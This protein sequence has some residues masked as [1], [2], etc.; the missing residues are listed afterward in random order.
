MI[1]QI[2]RNRFGFNRSRRLFDFPSKFHC[3]LHFL[4]SKRFLKMVFSI[5]FRVLQFVTFRIYFCFVLFH[6]Y[7]LKYGWFCKAFFFLLKKKF[8]F[9][10]A[11]NSVW[12]LCL[13][14]K[15]T[16]CVQKW[17]WNGKKSN[18]LHVTM[19]TNGCKT[20]S[21]AHLKCEQN[22]FLECGPIAIVQLHM[23]I[24]VNCNRVNQRQYANNSMRCLLF[25]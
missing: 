19:V 25:A 13:I 6:K 7:S 2:Y 21:E 4:A 18:P 11:E 5:V 16:V 14:V 1:H 24:G 22:P 12:T 9:S 17:M 10:E 15:G 3:F 23:D 8:A 20:I